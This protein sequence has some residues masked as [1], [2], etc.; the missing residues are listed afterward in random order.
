MFCLTTIRAIRQL[1]LVRFF[2]PRLRV[3]RLR[4]RIRLT[5]ILRAAH[6]AIANTTPYQVSIDNTVMCFS[7]ANFTLTTTYTG[8]GGGSPLVTNFSLPVGLAGTNYMFSHDN[9]RNNSG[10]RNSRCGQ[11]G[12]DGAV[13]VTL[14]AGWGS[15]VYGIPVTSLSAGTNGMLTVNGAAATTFTNSALLGAVG[16]ANPTLFPSWDD[17]DMD[18]AD[19]VGGGIYVNTIGAAPN[20]EFYVEWRATQFADATTAINTNFAVKLTE[21]SGTIQY[22]YVLTG[23][24]PNADGV[25]ATV[26]IQ[27]AATAAS[28]VHAGW[29]QY[30]RQNSSVGTIL[31]V[32]LPAGSAHRDRAV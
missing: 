11:H 6:K 7:T 5:R 8:G 1:A 25:S 20:R 12:D 31:T 17:Y 32:T 18:P 30:C 10:W 9:R 16:G 22:I 26:G 24:A 2:R 15:T 13:T 19:T 14:P 21:G 3:L 27:R 28:P 4:N 23:V 29:F